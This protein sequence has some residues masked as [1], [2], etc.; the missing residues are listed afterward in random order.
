M[1]ARDLVL[2]GVVVVVLVYLWLTYRD[3]A[4]AAV[5]RAELEAAAKRQSE[6]D[7]L[8]E[9][10]RRIDSACR[11]ADEPAPTP[12]AEESAHAALDSSM[13]TLNLALPA[14]EEAIV[15]AKAWQEKFGKAFSAIE[16]MERER[17]VWKQMYYDAGLGHMNA[18][19]MLF[20]EIERLSVVAKTPV[21]PHL[22][23][24]V[25]GY[26]EKHVLSPD[27]AEAQVAAAS[28]PDPRGL[29]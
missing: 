11:A 26:R 4:A 13:R 24:L 21:R 10:L 9:S 18:Q 14:L 8:D 6:R 5:A 15:E 3:R 1:S 19:E 23:D 2:I 28:T 25:N 27:S 17:N 22:A 7:K 20:R 29:G 12:T 16:Q